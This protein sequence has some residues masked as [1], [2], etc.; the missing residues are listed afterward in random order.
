MQH[1]IL[2]SYTQSI[3]SLQLLQQ[4]QT[5]GAHQVDGH[6]LL[7]GEQWLQV[8]HAQLPQHTAVQSP[9]EFQA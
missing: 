5:S 2:S 8:C 6:I 9:A 1:V 7:P 3:L 4:R